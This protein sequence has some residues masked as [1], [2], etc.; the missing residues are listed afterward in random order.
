M[1][2]ITPWGINAVIQ[3]SWAIYYDLGYVRRSV[4]YNPSWTDGDGV[5]YRIFMYPGT[6][7]FKWLYCKDST[8]GI[9]K[10]KIN[11]VVAATF[12]TYSVSGVQNVIGTQAGITISPAGVKA[13]HVIVDGKNP[14][15]T[16]YY[17]V[18]SE[19]AFYRTA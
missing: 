16:G 15:S 9:V 5:E 17:C 10:I 19:M 12:D 3:G 18:F 7:T 6:Y 14:L 2:Y 4:Y 11:D 1:I 13:I 8:F